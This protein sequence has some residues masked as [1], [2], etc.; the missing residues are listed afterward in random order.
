VLCLNDKEMQTH[1]PNTLLSVTNNQLHVLATY[2][3]LQ[4]EHNYNSNKSTN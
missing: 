1:S 3:H 4:A 2:S